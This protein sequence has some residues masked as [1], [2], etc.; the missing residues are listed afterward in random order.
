[1][2]PDVRALIA[3]YGLQHLPVEGTLY[4][5]TFTAAT[6]NAIV[7]MF[8]A[9]PPSF[10]CFHTL[11]QD[12]MWHFYGGD[13]LRLILLHGDGTSEDVVLGTDIAAGQR[14]QFNIPAGTMQ[15]GELVPGGRYA[16]YGCT[17][18]PAFD[19][20]G[21]D[22]PDEATLLARWPARADDIRRLCVRGHDRAMPDG[23]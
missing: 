21:F 17:L 11:V 14:V 22:A 2:D 10:S 1:M 16:L 15:A 18:T 5:R 13:P 9:D 19:P 20:K 6:H 4:A 8:C 7:G 12:E 23:Y 3:H